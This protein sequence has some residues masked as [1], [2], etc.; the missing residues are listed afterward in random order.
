MGD[1]KQRLYEPYIFL[2][3]EWEHVGEGVLFDAPRI[4]GLEDIADVMLDATWSFYYSEDE[5]S[6]LVLTI[7]GGWSY[8]REFQKPWPAPAATTGRSN[9]TPTGAP[10]GRGEVDENDCDDCFLFRIFSGSDLPDVGAG[11]PA[12]D[13]GYG[14]AADSDTGR[15]LVCH[16][17]SF[18]REGV[19]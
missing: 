15:R 10:R 4:T 19:G 8:F 13:G 14:L 1:D 17:A 6:S 7:R 16:D 12:H 11:A 3:G 5:L 18:E 9:G 2:G